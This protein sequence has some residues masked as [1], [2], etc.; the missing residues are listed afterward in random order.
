VSLDLWGPRTDRIEGADPAL[1]VAMGRTVGRQERLAYTATAAGTYFLAA[2]LQ[3][4]LRNRTL[5]RLALA[6]V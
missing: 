6:R 2:T 1:R 3:D 5:Y 4:G